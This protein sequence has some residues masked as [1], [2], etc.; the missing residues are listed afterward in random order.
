MA[1][2]GEV[3]VVV[4]AELGVSGLAPWA[5]QRRRRV[6]VVAAVGQGFSGGGSDGVDV[7]HLAVDVESKVTCSEQG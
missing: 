5:F 2:L 6:V 4:V 1:G 3:V 7:L